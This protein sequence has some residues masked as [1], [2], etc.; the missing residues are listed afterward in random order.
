M[1]ESREPN[2][3]R[4]RGFRKTVAKAG[5]EVGAALVSGLLFLL[6]PLFLTI[7]ALRVITWHVASVLRQR[8]LRRTR[9]R[10]G[11]CS[12]RDVPYLNV[13]GVNLPF[14]PFAVKYRG[15]LFVR[16][17]CRN[18]QSVP[19]EQGRKVCICARDHFRPALSGWLLGG[20]VLVL[21]WVAVLV[22]GVWGVRHGSALLGLPPR[23]HTQHLPAIDVRRPLNIPA[24]EKKKAAD[25]VR[26]AR[27]YRAAKRYSA[28]RIEY[29]NAIQRDP[30][31]VD[32]Y[33]GLAE[34]CLQLGFF[35]EAKEALTRVIE[36]DPS[37]PAAYRRLTELAGRQHDFDQAFVHARK[38]CGLQPKDKDARLLLSSC[39]LAVGDFSN[40]SHEVSLAMSFAPSDPEPLLSAAY[41]EILKKNPAGAEDYYK[42]VMAV[43]AT[44]VSARI[45]LARIYSD[46]GKMVEAEGFLRSILKA[47]PDCTDAVLEL[48]S[49]KCRQEKWREAVEIYRGA[50]SF[51]PKLYPVREELARILMN[52]GRI[53]E[54]YDVASQLII[55]DPENVMAYLILCETFLDRGFISLAE[56]YARKALRINPNIVASHRLMARILMK[57]GDLDRSL[58]YFKRLAAALPDDMES[59]LRLGFCLEVKGDKEKALQVLKKAVERFPDSPLPYFHLGEIYQRSKEADKAV[60]SYRQA[61]A[62]KPENPAALNNLAALLLDQTRADQRSIDEAFQ[63]AGRAWELAPRNAGVA[64]TLGWAHFRKGNL[65]EAMALLFHARQMAPSSPEVL[66][67]LG[68]VYRAKGK[69]DMARER[70]EAALRLSADFAGVAAA[71]ALLAEIRQQR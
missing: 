70:L 53:D 67:H 71:R 27:E 65:D 7:D 49:L 46:R 29:R 40:A 17:L 43:S 58:G 33:L 69:T 32:G 64:D 52:N 19:D 34:C 6:S 20:C 18:S 60:D 36:L 55:A 39:Y 11:P 42:K 63:L 21:M 38:L 44:N 45:G 31:L 24:S 8:L 1:V 54:G 28:A 15:S 59:Q 56:D 66:Y 68:C 50:V 30:L 12:R 62:R 2:L 9:V 37:S 13:G 48:G 61:V 22:A 16:I 51:Y 3:R 4:R 41:V 47:Q 10:L 57:R 23:A 14:C 26:G 5:R 25:F 35:G